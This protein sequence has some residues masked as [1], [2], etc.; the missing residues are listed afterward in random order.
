MLLETLYPPRSMLIVA[1]DIASPSL[2]A[3]LVLRLALCAHV[4]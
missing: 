1:L 4:Y 3:D 2:P